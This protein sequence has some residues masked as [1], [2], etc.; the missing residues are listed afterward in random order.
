MIRPLSGEQLVF[1]HS[2]G[3]P[4]PERANVVDSR[5]FRAS[6]AL[7]GI[8]FLSAR[9]ARRGQPFSLQLLDAK[10]CVCKCSRMDVSET[11]LLHSAH[12]AHVI[13]YEALRRSCD[14]NR[15]SKK[16]II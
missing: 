4:H 13:K 8:Y 5:L 15:K 10:S 1:Y 3:F 6:E 16:Q 14:G 12:R 9:H 2:A 11:E 7:R